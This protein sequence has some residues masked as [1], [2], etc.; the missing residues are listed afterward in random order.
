MLCS[1]IQLENWH[2]SLLILQLNCLLF[3][4]DYLF[5]LSIAS[6]NIQF[7]SQ[8]SEHLKQGLNEFG[9]FLIVPS[10]VHFSITIIIFAINWPYC[11]FYSLYTLR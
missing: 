2:D 5:L 4:G 10:L 8:F 6:N 7:T 11:A 1:H 9:T 3:M